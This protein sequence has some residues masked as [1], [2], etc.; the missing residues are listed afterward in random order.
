VFLRLRS[1]YR[2]W[3][4]S[5]KCPSAR[6]WKPSALRGSAESWKSSRPPRVNFNLLACRPTLTLKYG[7]HVHGSF[8]PLVQRRADTCIYYLSN[9]CCNSH[10]ISVFRDNCKGMEV[11]WEDTRSSEVEANRRPKHSHAHRRS[12]RQ[13]PNHRNH[14]VTSFH[15]HSHLNYLIYTT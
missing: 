12:S 9:E 4:V 7:L 10:S 11:N 2:Q 5:R 14:A 13:P 6:G 1:S 15:P 8:T 3:L